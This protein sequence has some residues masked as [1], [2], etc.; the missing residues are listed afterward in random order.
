MKRQR[1]R[2]M[3][4][5]RLLLQTH[6]PALHLPIRQMCPPSLP[7]QMRPPSLPLQMC[8]PSLLPLQMCPPSLPLPNPPLRNL[9]LTTPKVFHLLH[10]LLSLAIASRPSFDALTASG[11]C[12]KL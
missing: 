1:E 6:A 3:T 9:T 8:P 5:H 10:Q 4:I 12:P 2:I 11:P 7:L